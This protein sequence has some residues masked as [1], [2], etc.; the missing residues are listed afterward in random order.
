MTTPK[1]ACDTPLERN[2]EFFVFWIGRRFLDE[3]LPDIA[4]KRILYL[5]D[6]SINVIWRS[7]REHFHGS[8]RQIADKAG[9]ARAIGY[10]VSGEAK[11]HALNMAAKNYMFGNLA[12]F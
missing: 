2:S 11:A 10:M 4:G 8:I 6:T 5:V 1:M 9:Q 7:L 12:H 3:C